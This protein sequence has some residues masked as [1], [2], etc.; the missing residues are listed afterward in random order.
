MIDAPF[1]AGSC[2]LFESLLNFFPDDTQT[3]TRALKLFDM[4]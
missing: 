3:I 2:D 4:G 1:D